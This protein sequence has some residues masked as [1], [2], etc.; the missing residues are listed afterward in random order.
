ML[1]LPAGLVTV[2]V[3]P[4]MFVRIADDLL[5]CLGPSFPHFVGLV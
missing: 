2:L 3:L 5:C 1:L 4:C